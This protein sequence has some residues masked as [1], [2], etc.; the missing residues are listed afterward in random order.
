MNLA[1]RPDGTPSYQV[2]AALAGRGFAVRREDMRNLLLATHGKVFT[3][4]TIRHIVE[5]TDIR[6]LATKTPSSD[7]GNSAAGA[8]AVANAYATRPDT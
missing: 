5:H 8:E 6:R 3:L 1:R 4:S 2:V 7:R